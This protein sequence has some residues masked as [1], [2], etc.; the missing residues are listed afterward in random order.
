MNIFQEYVLECW[1]EILFIFWKLLKNFNNFQIFH[2]SKNYDNS[3]ISQNLYIL[4]ILTT[5]EI[6][7]IVLVSKMLQFYQFY[8]YK[9]IIT[10]LQL[11]IYIYC[12][13]RILS[14]EYVSFQ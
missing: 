8:Y 11:K 5:L 1:I 14:W 3:K 2:Y 13:F 12:L 7:K 10:N 6:L 4:K 9:I